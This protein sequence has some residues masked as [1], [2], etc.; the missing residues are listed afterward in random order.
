VVAVLADYGLRGELKTGE[1]GVWVNG[2]KICSFGIAVKKW[3]SSHGIAF[4]VNNDLATFAMIV[5]CGRPQENVTSVAM[6]L[7]QQLDMSELK[8]KFIQHFLAA[9]AYHL[10]N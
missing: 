5:P 3:I 6:E 1:P 9:F 4:N 8:Q 2:R 10:K 7:G